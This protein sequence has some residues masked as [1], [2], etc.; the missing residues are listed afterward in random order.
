MNTYEQREQAALARYKRNMK[1]LTARLDRDLASARARYF[2]KADTVMQA[3]LRESF[4]A[5]DAGREAAL[6]RGR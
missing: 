2:K 4:A 6:Q 3:Y 1:P 5:F